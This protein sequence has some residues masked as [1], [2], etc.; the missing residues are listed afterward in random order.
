MYLDSSDVEFLCGI[1]EVGFVESNLKFRLV[2]SIKIENCEIKVL[3]DIG[4]FVN[5]MDE[6]I[7]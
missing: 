4:V 7:F 6:C 3:I 2:R 1:E 5:V